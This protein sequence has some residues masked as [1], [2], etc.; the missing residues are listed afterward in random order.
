MQRGAGPVSDLHFQGVEGVSGLESIYSPPVAHLQAGSTGRHGDD[1]PQ[2]FLDQVVTAQ[3]GLPD[4]GMWRRSVCIV[5]NATEDVAGGLP[6]RVGQAGLEPAVL[7]KLPRGAG[8]LESVQR[9]IRVARRDG[10]AGGG[11]PR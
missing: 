2:A 6:G 11:D 9:G 7:D 10:Q 1:L 3:P 5:Q 4:A 8:D